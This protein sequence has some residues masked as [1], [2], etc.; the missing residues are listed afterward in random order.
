VTSKKT[1]A[2]ATMTE[3]LGGKLW[4]LRE[5]GEVT[6]GLMASTIED[7]GA[8][9]SV[10]FPDTAGS[11]EA[12]DVIAIIEGDRDTFE[13]TAPLD[14][15]ILEVNGAAE[16]EPNIISDD[17]TEE[18]WVIKLEPMDLDE[19]EEED[20]DEDLDEEDED[21]DDEDDGEEED[22]EEEDDEDD[23]D[24]DDEDE[25]EDFDD[26]DDEDSEEEEESDDDDRR[27]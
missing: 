9:Q 14:G 15:F 13:V 6:V 22:D 20:E 16:D 24:F 23:E 7:I 1:S 19:S 27:R 25:D 17:P 4:Y 21:F 10:D 2:V 11:V 12:G 8:V 3:F 5:G 18:G 26:E